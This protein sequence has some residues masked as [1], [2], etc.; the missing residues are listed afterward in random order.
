MRSK[1]L[2]NCTICDKD[3]K[4]EADVRV[5][6]E[7]IEKI[8][9]SITPT[10]NDEVIECADLLLMPS[11]F[12]LNTRVK[13]SLLT[14]KNLLSLAEN[15]QKAGVYDITLIPEC[16]PQIKSEATIEFVRST[17]SGKLHINPSIL[18]IK[19][20]FSISDI[21]ILSKHNCNT[22]YLESH[23]AG[24]LLRRIFEY[25]NMWNSLILCRCDDLSISENGVMNEG[26]L[27]SKL[28][29]PGIS[30]IYETKEVAKL[31]EFAYSIKARM[32]FSALSSPRSL[33]IIKRAKKNDSLDIYSEVSI[34]HLALSED[35]CEDYNTY[36][37]IMPPLQSSSTKDAL[38]QALKDESIDV[39]TSLHSPKS[40][41]KKD[42]AFEEALYGIDSIGYFFS[43]CY[44]YLV[45]EGHI[46]L[47]NLSSLISYNPASIVGAEGRGVIK[48]GVVDGFVLVDL[49]ESFVVFD[50]SSPYYKKELFGKVYEV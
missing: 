37:K 8:A 12:D 15:A 34:H 49:D 17:S 24:N 26:Y 35:A 32:L 25:A 28:G 20:D 19:N 5:C 42:M 46:S 6:E 44:T 40:I 45:K 18:S 4:Y 29:L 3:G 41:N 21:S 7:R 31:I 11:F 22:I 50:K 43:L 33:E 13:D 47:E 30:S 10:N 27:S 39:L 14:H 2:K 23:K 16:S 9:S 36:A 38:L 48:E 1:L